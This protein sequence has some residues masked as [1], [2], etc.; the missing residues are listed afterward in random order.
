MTTAEEST[1]SLTARLVQPGEPGWDNARQSFNGTIDRQPAAILSCAS[2]HDV[3]GAV[4]YAR[5]LGLPIAVRGGG[6]SVAGHC[7]A[8]G[9]IV[10]SLDRMR[11]VTVDAERRIAR[12]EG[13]GRTSTRRPRRSASP[14]RAGRS[15]IRVSEA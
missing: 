1:P 13:C 3:G 5:S 6:H 2:T 7:V 15:A 4:R 8:D 12:V 9:A 11:G 10:V 14:C